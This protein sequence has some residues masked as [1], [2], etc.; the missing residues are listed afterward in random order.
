MVDGKES[1][2][3][4]YLVTQVD[5]EDVTGQLT[6]TVITKQ[7]QVWVFAA[8]SD[9]GLDYV[10][11]PQGRRFKTYEPYGETP[12]GVDPEVWHFYTNIG[13]DYPNEEVIH[14]FSGNHA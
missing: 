3:A 12:I 5:G 4:P 9:P 13:N 7:R 2:T 11:T 1:M 10:V 8:Y 6:V 14:P